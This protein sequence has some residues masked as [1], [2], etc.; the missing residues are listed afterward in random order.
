MEIEWINKKREKESRDMIK[1][2]E[3][4]IFMIQGREINKL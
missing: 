1:L 2:K 3:K 4:E